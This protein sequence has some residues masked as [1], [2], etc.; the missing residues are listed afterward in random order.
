MDA[1]LHFVS[2]S[3]AE[4]GAPQTIF[5][6]WSFL[7][8]LGAGFILLC[9]YYSGLGFSLRARIFVSYAREP[10]ASCCRW[11]GI[12][13]AGNGDL[14]IAFWLAL[15]RFGTRVWFATFVGRND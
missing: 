9:V 3:R 2:G 6:V 10:D 15:Y 5:S 7:L 1:V 4:K 11:A 12:D 13:P 14:F 8:A